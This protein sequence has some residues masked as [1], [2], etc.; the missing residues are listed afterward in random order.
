MSIELSFEAQ[1]WC[2]DHAELEKLYNKIIAAYNYAEES[3][4]DSAFEFCEEIEKLAVGIK[5]R[6]SDLE[7]RIERRNEEPHDY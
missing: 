6:L 3:D 5:R 1:G 7:E 2:Q 4:Y